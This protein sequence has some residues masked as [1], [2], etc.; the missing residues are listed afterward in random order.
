MRQATARVR[1]LGPGDA[2]SLRA[3]LDRDPVTNVFVDARVEAAGADPLRR[4]RD[5]IWGYE[6]DASMVS[7]CYAGANLV[8]VDATSRAAV[9][10][11]RRA[12]DGPRRCS[13]VWGPRSAVRPMWRELEPSWGPARA[14]RHQQPFLVL[15]RPPEVAPDPSVRRVGMGELEPAYRA[16]AAFFTEELGIS[17][18]A[19]GGGHYYRGRVE[20]L[21]RARRMFA[22]IERGE[23]V[24][25]AEIGVAT[26][27][28]FQVQGVWVAP[29]WRGRGLAGPAMAAVV[30]A[31]LAEVAP[32]ATLYVNDFNVP[33]RRAYDRLGFAQTDTFMTVLF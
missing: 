29:A 6:E 28:A 31:G 9:A 22:R 3:V 7:A 30:S 11:A 13:S 14:I 33:A 20:E 1:R 5:T 27:R 8:P 12:L 18:E 10:F 32:V 19:G 2:D 23:I 16:C 15:D 17:P 24:F 26:P 25:K 21:I 4:G